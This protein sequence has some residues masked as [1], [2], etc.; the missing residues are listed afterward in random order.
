MSGPGR[1]NRV[2]E[3]A[4]VTAKLLIIQGYLNAVALERNTMNGRKEGKWGP[5]LSHLRGDYDVLGSW[6]LSMNFGRIW[7]KHLVC[8]QILEEMPWLDS[9]MCLR[10]FMGGCV[11]DGL[12]CKKQSGRHLILSRV[13]STLPERSSHHQTPRSVPC[14]R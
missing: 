5:S 7:L 3:K 8:C 11:A 14:A 4:L 12:A 10:R 2:T 9:M 1:G 13:S 6:Y